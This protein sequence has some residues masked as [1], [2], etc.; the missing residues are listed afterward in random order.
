MKRQL[1]LGIT[2]IVTLS[3]YNNS[4]AQKKPIESEQ[5]ISAYVSVPF[6]IIANVSY[7]KLWTGKKH[8]NGLTTGFTMNYW[9]DDGTNYGVHLT[10]TFLSSVSYKHH[11]EFKLG[12]VY[13][14]FLNSPDWSPSFIP[15][16]TLGYRY[17]PPDSKGFFRIALSTG[18]LGL[19][20]GVRIGG[21][22]N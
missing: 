8:F 4:T 2:L 20:A 1:I 3:F 14:I 17:Q 15:V 21:N 5:F 10:Y 9:G 11:F 13:N 12:G 7:D 16:V 18:G 22:S 6:G 19:G